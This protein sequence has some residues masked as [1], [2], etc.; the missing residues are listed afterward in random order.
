MNP[1]IQ[2]KKAAPIFLV[3]L[4][5]GCFALLQRVQAKDLD[6]VLPGG[7]AGAQGQTPGAPA[8]GEVHDRAVSRVGPGVTGVSITLSAASRRRK[9]VLLGVRM[10]SLEP[11]TRACGEFT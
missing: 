2:L 4:V 9:A 7:A 11:A 5:L 10:K 8:S 3:G 1:L 6:G